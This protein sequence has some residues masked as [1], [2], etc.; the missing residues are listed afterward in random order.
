MK[1]V[2]IK[3]ENIPTLSD[4]RLRNLFLNAI[5]IRLDPTNKWY[6]EAERA[7]AAIQDTWSDRVRRQ[8]FQDYKADTPEEGMLKSVG[9][10]V[11]ENG[12]SYEVR[13]RLLDFL[14]EGVLPP[15][16]SPPYYEDWG[17]P[18]SK[19]RYRKLHR[20]IRVLASS[21]SHFS[22]MEKAAREWEDD[23]IYIEDKWGH[24]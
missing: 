17:E 24:L 4:V 11:G 10:K 3:I 5:K 8:Q 14:I 18:S 1:E 15:A 16:G 6:D 21:A 22:N 20:V 13:H 7:I 23:L 9:Y 2:A 19:Q 12:E